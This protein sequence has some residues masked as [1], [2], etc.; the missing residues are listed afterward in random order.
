MVSTTKELQSKLKQPRKWERV[1][2]LKE[3]RLDSSEWKGGTRHYV[4]GCLA[5]YLVLE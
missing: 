2:Y 3:K 5:N 1:H 4:V